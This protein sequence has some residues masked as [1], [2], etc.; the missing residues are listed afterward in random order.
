MNVL[1]ESFPKFSLKLVVFEMIVM[2]GCSKNS[3]NLFHKAPMD[4]SGWMKKDNKAKLVIEAK[5]Y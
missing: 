3:N 5:W 4:A 2:G 1:L